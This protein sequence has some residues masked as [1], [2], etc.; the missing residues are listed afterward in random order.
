MEDYY[1]QVNCAGCGTETR[2]RVIN[3]DEFPVFCAMCGMENESNQIEE[4]DYITS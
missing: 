3:E 4:D 2:I 1:H